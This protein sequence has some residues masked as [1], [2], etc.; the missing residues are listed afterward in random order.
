M[1]SKALYSSKSG[2]WET[3]APL[4]QKLDAE[5]HFTLDVCA[6]PH[7]KKCRRFFSPKQNGLR[8]SWAGETAWCNPPYG[9]GVRRWLAKAVA[10]SEQG[11][12]TVMLLPVRTDTEAFQ[13]YAMHHAQELRFIKGRV[14]FVRPPA[15]KQKPG[16]KR[17]RTS[18]KRA[19]IA[20]FPSVLV[21][22]RGRP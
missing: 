3:P 18:R 5:F 1:V 17:K 14:P 15:Q 4:F 12:T 7:N 2:R 16:T 19:T 9:R 13:K 6:E 21:V 11:A 20:P 8:R 22:F 10:E